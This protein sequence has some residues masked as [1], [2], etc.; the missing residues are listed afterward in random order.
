MASDTDALQV[1]VPQRE[2]FEAFP[3]YWKSGSL[4][5]SAG[6]LPACRDN[7]GGCLPY[8]FRSDRNSERVRA[9]SLKTPSK[10]D[11]FITEFCFSTPRIRSEERRVG[12]SVSV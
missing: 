7:L 9:S 4:P 8:S 11:V 6:R 12:K 1:L 3:C 5:D 2:K 10:Q